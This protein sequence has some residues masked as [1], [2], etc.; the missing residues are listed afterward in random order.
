MNENTQIFTV[1]NFD[2]EVLHSELPV[3]VDFWAE[4]CGPCRAIG[5]VIDAIA[6]E[7]AGTALVGKVNVD[8]QSPIA[9]AYYVRS[10]PALMV[11]KGGEMVE[12]I[13]SR[14]KKDILA[15]LQRHA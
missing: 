8:E 11:F 6:F 5:P 12:Q 2:T 1:D 14:D 7:T 3:L 13:S 9:V 10:I 15:A 4:W